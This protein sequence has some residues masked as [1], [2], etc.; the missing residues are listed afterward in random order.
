MTNRDCKIFIILSCV[1]GF[2]NRDWWH[3][4]QLPFK[5]FHHFNIVK[6]NS[7]SIH[8]LLL[9]FIGKLLEWS[10]LVSCFLFVISLTMDLVIDDF[11]IFFHFAD[12]FSLDVREGDRIYFIVLT[13]V[14]KF[15]ISFK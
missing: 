3:F 1:L 14:K 11:V 12:H 10:E 2:N 4:G 15:Q 7:L 9:H 13:K 6:L 8:E 5:I